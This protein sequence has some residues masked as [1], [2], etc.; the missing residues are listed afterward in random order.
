MSAPIDDDEFAVAMSS[1]SPFEVPPRLAVAVSGGADSL[2][3]CLLADRWARQRGGAVLALTVDHGL[4]PESIGEATQVAAWLDARTMAHETL[5]WRQTAPA[6]I[7]QTTARAARYALLEAA[8]RRHRIWHLL[9]GHTADDQAETLLMRLAKG[10]GVDGLAGIAPVRETPWLRLLRPLLGQPKARL[11][12]TCR[13]AGQGWI[14]DPS[15]HDQRFTRGR[16]RTVETALAAEGLTSASLALS[17]QR[18]GRTRAALE[19]GTAELLAAIAAFR[20]EGYALIDRAGLLAAQDEFARRALARLLVTLGGSPYPPRFQRLDRLFAAVRADGPIHRTLAGC[21]ILSRPGGPSGQL[22]IC[23]EAAAARQRLT[24]V[25]GSTLWWDRRFVIAVPRTLP[26]SRVDIARLGPAGAKALAGTA[27][28]AAVR[29][30]LPGLYQ[31]QRL[32]G[33]PKL[34]GVDLS[35]P[36]LTLVRVDVVF[37]AGHPAAGALSTVVPGGSRITY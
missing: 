18:L 6:Q 21:R 19:G 7:R 15:N 16:L 27:A 32:V 23:R 8:C 14:K 4:R 1:F 33:I 12:A 35:G 22:L 34:P 24:A 10:S 36:S 30:A 11:L 9:L 37:S 28:P 13:A 29:Q 31:G 2:A 25:P 5:T 20:P 17:T 3:L 26:V